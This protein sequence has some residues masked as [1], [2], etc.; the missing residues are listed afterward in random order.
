MKIRACPVCG[1]KFEARGAR[2]YCGQECYKA[3]QKKLEQKRAAR[4]QPEL[5]TNDPPEWVDR[6]LHCEEEDCTGTCP[7]R[8]GKEYAARVRAVASA[9]QEGLTIKEAAKRVGI[10]PNQ[11]GR[12]MK[13]KLYSD[14]MRKAK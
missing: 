5:Y 11:V 1:A 2:K 8:R 10:T 9:I 13:T 12:Y 4:A 14:C 6:C 7:E 3:A